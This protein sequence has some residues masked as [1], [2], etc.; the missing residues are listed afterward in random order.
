MLSANLPVQNERKI[1]DIYTTRTSPEIFVE[2]SPEIKIDA[3]NL[4]NLITT[5]QN[6]NS[7]MGIVGISTNTG[8]NLGT[9]H[10]TNTSWDSSWVHR[11]DFARPSELPSWIS[12]IFVWG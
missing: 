1:D 11:S 2:P 10:G 7:D 9:Q 6:I 8:T 12:K 4:S 3:S 5:T